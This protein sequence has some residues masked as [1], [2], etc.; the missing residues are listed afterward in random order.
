MNKIS[1]NTK[2]KIIYYIIFGFFF[3]LGEIY[4]FL[5]THWYPMI[6]ML[7]LIIIYELK[8]QQFNINKIVYYY[9]LT[10][11][12]SL[13]LLGYYII[14]DAYIMIDFNSLKSLITNL[15]IIMFLFTLRKYDLYYVI[16]GMIIGYYFNIIY[17]MFQ[18]MNLDKYIFF[19]SQKL[20]IFDGRISLTYPEPS[21]AGAYILL[22]QLLFL[23]M[24]ENKN[25]TK[26]KYLYYSILNSIIMILIGSKGAIIIFLLFL[27]F[28]HN[29]KYLKVFVTI[30]IFF[31]ILNVDNLLS[32][33]AISQMYRLVY[34]TSDLHNIFFSTDSIVVRFLSPIAGLANII[35]FPLGSTS[36]N[37]LYAYQQAFENI[38]I[39]FKSAELTGYI[40][41]QS[42]SSFKN[43]YI[44][45]YYYLGPIVIYV[46]YK[47]FKG[48]KNNYKDGI[49]I[50]II[51]VLMGA[52]LEL[53]NYLIWF[54]LFYLLKK[55]KNIENSIHNRA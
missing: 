5:F 49:K 12:F 23:F 40:S 22:M 25:L 43:Y 51:L 19:I 17:G 11:L 2:I 32:I 6:P 41:D 20:T 27:V 24:Y 37:T 29:T 14:I 13:L 21:A 33:P 45:M 44:N 26:Y 53:F 55:E 9:L 28:Y 36:F 15:I 10:I 50:L 46:F 42:N 39:P 34:Y 30:I 3:T 1:I 31:I 18:F 7:F 54:I 48:I 8:K 52:I 47:V 4:T 35:N 16:K 38:N